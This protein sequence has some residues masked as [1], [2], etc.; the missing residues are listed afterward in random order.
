VSGRLITAAVLEPLTQRGAVVVPFGPGQARMLAV[1]RRIGRGRITMLAIN[2]TDPTLASWTGLDTLLRTLV[3]R[4][5]VEN[6]RRIEP[7]RYGYE[8]LGGR[9]LNWTRYTARDLGTTAPPER[10]EPNPQGSLPLDI[11][12]SKDPVA[13]WIDTSSELPQLARATLE[14]SSGITIPGSGFVLRVILS[15]IAALVP[16]NWLLCRFVFRRKEL[17]WVVAPLLAFG[18]AYGVERAAAVNLGFDVACDEIDVVE[19]QSGYGRAHLTRMASIYSTGRNEYTITETDNP[20]SL[21]LPMKSFES[22]RREE[23]RYS[24]YETTPDPQMS[25]FLVQPRS[26]DMFRAEALVELGGTITL[27]GSLESGKLINGTDLELRD[28]VLIDT[29]SGRTMELGHVAPRPRDEAEVQAGAFQITLPRLPTPGA[30]PP[31][32]EETA[33]A[34]L[35]NFLGRLRDFRWATPFDAGE[36]RLVAWTRQPQPG[37]AVT[38]NVDR[39]RGVRLVVAHLRF[40]PVAY[41]QSQYLP[42]PE[43]RSAAAGEPDPN[44]SLRA[45]LPAQ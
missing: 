21:V 25:E 7:N 34:D 26:L 29:A 38:P 2:P 23:T 24:R 42:L 22:L 13:A 20:T 19:I 33:W 12:F 32:D 15:Y 9:D 8:P 40:P 4:R 5:A 27:E 43:S 11:N 14:K 44:P 41:D 16:L 31:P 35:P 18:F 6:W 17:A 45:E 3:F 37:I 36:I 1:E 10:S 39:H 30:T 28:A